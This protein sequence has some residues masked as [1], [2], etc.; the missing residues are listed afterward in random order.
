MKQAHRSSV[1]FG[2][3]LSGELP[4]NSAVGRRRSQSSGEGSKNAIFH[5]L[6]GQQWP[7]YQDLV[8]AETEL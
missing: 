5:T 2:G 3:M 6:G 8:Y 4:G 7:L 1:S